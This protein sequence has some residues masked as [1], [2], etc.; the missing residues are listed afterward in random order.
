MYVYIY[1]PVYI[2]RSIENLSF[3]NI[4]TIKHNMHLQNYLEINV[5]V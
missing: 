4:K 5:T 2:N 1:I 3:A